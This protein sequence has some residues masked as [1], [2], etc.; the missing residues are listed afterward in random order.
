MERRSEPNKSRPR[1]SAS[2]KKGS[3]SKANSSKTQ[4]KKMDCS[5]NASGTD[6]GRKQTACRPSGSSKLK[7]TGQ[8]HKEHDMDSA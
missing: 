8:K 6:L 1:S 4:P 3:T 2:S 7:K 5:N